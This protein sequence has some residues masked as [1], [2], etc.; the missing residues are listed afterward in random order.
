MPTETVILNALSAVC[1]SWSVALKVKLQVV[2]DVGLGAVPVIAPVELFKLK[3]IV[4]AG[5]SAFDVNT[6]VVSLYATVESDVAATDND[7]AV[8]ATTVPNDPAAVVQVGASD[9]VN[10]AVDD[11][12]AVPSGFS[13]LI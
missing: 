6:L 7:T 2:S 3:F 5:V 1:D 9:T 10:N 4:L 13:T 8:P 12:T 11:L